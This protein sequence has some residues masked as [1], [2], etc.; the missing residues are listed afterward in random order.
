ML[1]A[2]RVARIAGC[3]G[4]RRRAHSARRVRLGH[5]TRHKS[6]QG[7]AALRLARRRQEALM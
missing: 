5:G 4:V 3:G 2:G 7:R 6:A 1:F